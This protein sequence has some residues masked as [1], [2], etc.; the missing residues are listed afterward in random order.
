MLKMTI[1]KKWGGYYHDISLW[2]DYPLIKLPRHPDPGKEYA[3]CFNHG[4]SP[5]VQGD[6]QPG[7]VVTVG[8]EFLVVERVT[9]AELRDMVR[10]CSSF[11]N[12][13]LHDLIREALEAYD[14]VDRGERAFIEELRQIVV[15][16]WDEDDPVETLL[17]MMD[18]LL[19]TPY[20]AMG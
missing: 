11:Y 14:V 3:L 20:D 18:T 8:L 10:R 9:C 17:E 15:D 1:E 13:A 16:N 6:L 5:L 12:V 2:A 7:T 19:D 4:S